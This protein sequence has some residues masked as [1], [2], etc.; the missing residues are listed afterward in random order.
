MR[1]WEKACDVF[2]QQECGKYTTL[3]VYL[4]ALDDGLSPEQV[5]RTPLP[6]ISA[7]AVER[8]SATRNAAG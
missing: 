1:V 5:E 7:L 8:S 2:T 4:N 3:E 6:C